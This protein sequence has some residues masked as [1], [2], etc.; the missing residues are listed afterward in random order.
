MEKYSIDLNLNSTIWRC[1]FFSCA[2]Q[3][4]HFQSVRF[5]QP[6]MRHDRFDFLSIASPPSKK[7]SQKITSPQRLIPYPI[8]AKKSLIT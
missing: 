8:L 4:Q 2:P 7:P 3:Q 5:G 1:I 6:V